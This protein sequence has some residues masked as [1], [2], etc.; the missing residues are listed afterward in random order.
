MTPWWMRTMILFK[1]IIAWSSIP[2]F[3]IALSPLSYFVSCLPLLMPHRFPL[4]PS[5][6]STHSSPLAGHEHRAP[7]KPITHYPFLSHD[8]PL[9]AHCS[10]LF[11]TTFCLL[12]SDSWLLSSPPYSP[13][14]ITHD[15]S[16][17][18][19][20][21]AH[22]SPLFTPHRHPQRTISHRKPCRP[23]ARIID[24]YSRTERTYF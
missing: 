14:P 13:L 20:S 11:S 7:Y 3:L 4:S 16:P 1:Y 15:H 8:S 23:C 9:T 17:A 6:L 18:H 12:S 5:P 19:R 2:I 22:S 10:L 24:K 21:L